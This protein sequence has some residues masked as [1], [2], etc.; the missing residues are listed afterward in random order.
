RQQAVAT[1]I[2]DY[3]HV[4]ERPERVEKIWRK[5]GAALEQTLALVDI[6]GRQARRARRGVAG[7]GVAVKKLYGSVGGGAHNRVVNALA[8]RDRTHRLRAV[9][10]ALGH[11]HQVRRD[12]EALRGECRPGAA[13]ATDY[14]VEDEKD[15]VRVADVAQS[16][17]IALR[18][19]QAAGRSGDRLDETGRDVLGA[20]KVDEA[21]QVFGQLDA[22]AA[23]A[24]DEEILL[25]VRVAHM[26]DARQ[27]RTESASIVD[28]AGQRNAAEIDTVVRTLA[29]DEH[30]APALPARLM[31]GERDFHRRVDRLGTGIDEKNPVQVARRELG[32]ASGEL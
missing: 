22:L 11:G 30:V 27:R 7:I 26:R 12:A 5:R 8:D 24:G 18:R 31:I 4:L 3:R 21:Q 10:D 2:G 15:A 23:F 32:D 17:Q 29:G 20:V 13:E 1:N 9:G 16:L 25:D 19:H 14:L 28:H 6:Q